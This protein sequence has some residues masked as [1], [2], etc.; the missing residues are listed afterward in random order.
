MT[1][2]LKWH[3]FYVATGDLDAPQLTNEPQKFHVERI[4]HIS[5]SMQRALRECIEWKCER[6]TRDSISF[7]RKKKMCCFLYMV[8]QAPIVSI[9]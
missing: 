8:T 1:A 5:R 2:T 4:V 7:S 3:V 6:V 9:T